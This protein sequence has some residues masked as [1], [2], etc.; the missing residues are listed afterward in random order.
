MSLSAVPFYSSLVGKEVG[1]LKLTVGHVLLVGAIIV[2]GGGK[3]NRCTA[4]VETL[5]DEVAQSEA[6]VK[7]YRSALISAGLLEIVEAD[8]HSG[9]IKSIAVTDLVTE[10][11]KDKSRL[12]P[13]K[14]SLKG[15]QKIFEATTEVATEVGDNIIEMNEEETTCAPRVRMKPTALRQQ[16]SLIFKAKDV[17]KS[18]SLNAIRKL[19]EQFDD[20]QVILD[21]AKKMKSRGEIKFK[22]GTTWKADYFWF[23][24]PD[25]TDAVVR[26]ILRMVS[27]AL[28]EEELSPWDKKRYD[29]AIKL[30]VARDYEDCRDNWGMI[31]PKIISTPE[32]RELENDR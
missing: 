12:R 8:E 6:T 11:L 9:Y 24:N 18:R 10:L 28:S 3:L 21:A 32:Y 16:L 7:N 19:Q 30:G 23:V 14:K 1:G 25:K 4:S 17:T 31:L 13:F 29:L 15:S 2:H 20:D 5:A 26:G 22:D 27:S